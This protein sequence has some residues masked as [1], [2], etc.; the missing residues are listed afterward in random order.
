MRYTAPDCVT[1]M[2]YGRP[3]VHSCV[4]MNM[5]HVLH[6][7]HTFQT[8]GILVSSDAGSQRVA[9]WQSSQLRVL[10]AL[11]PLAVRWIWCQLYNTCA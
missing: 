7:F 10:I 6:G 4:V 5:T 1:T 2:R 3:H 9:W 8:A 11:L